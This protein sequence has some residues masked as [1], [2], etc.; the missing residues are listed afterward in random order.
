MKS[1]IAVFQTLNIQ[2]MAM[3]I[4]MVTFEVDLTDDPVEVLTAI[5]P[6]Q[7]WLVQGGLSN[8]DVLEVKEGSSIE[9][10]QAEL[11]DELERHYRSNVG[12]WQHIGNVKVDEH[13]NQTFERE[14]KMCGKSHLSLN[15][16]GYCP[17]CWTVWNG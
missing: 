17:S 15:S 16:E 14:C 9:Q 2:T 6:F 12:D 7:M 5:C 13:G 4:D 1:L 8:L 10:A 3:Q 11:E